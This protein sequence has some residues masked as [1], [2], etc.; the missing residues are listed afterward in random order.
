MESDDEEVPSLIQLE[1]AVNII[2]DD[3]NHIPGVGPTL[4]DDESQ[5]N[6]TSLLSPFGKKI[7]VIILS[8]FLGAGKSTLINFILKCPDHNLKIAVIENEFGRS[9]T[10]L[11]I[12]SIIAKDGVESL[13][14]LIELPNGCVCCTVKS[15]LVQ[16][17]EMLHKRRPDLDYY[18]IELSGMANPGPIA[19]IFWLDE[20]LDSR[21]QLNGIVTLVDAL[22]ISH[23]LIDT[24]EASQQIAYADRVIL[25]KVDLI[26]E[27][28]KSEVY[29]V[30][31]SIHPTAPIQCTS[32]A[33]IPDLKWVLSTQGFDK[34]IEINKMAWSFSQCIPI[35]PS[36]HK[37]TRDVGT[38]TLICKG[39]VDLKKINQWMAL[40]L[41]PN[42][43]ESAKS[44]NERL[45]SQ[46]S[47]HGLTT[48]GNMP[49][50]Q[51][52][53]LKGILSVKHSELE[54]E[55]IPFIDKY[56][57]DSR[58]YV[59][60]GV[61]DL[62]EVH[63]ASENLRWADDEERICNIVIIG[64]HLQEEVLNSGLQS[65]LV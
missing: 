31:R 12:E 58:R 21:L 25:N 62:W 57:V 52:F 27:K 42:Q 15:D 9:T 32:Y 26:S 30:I 65:C 24:E 48:A 40:L 4:N 47:N 20:A 60:Q 43:D 18:L 46:L 19:S 16:A 35:V 10:E 63:A 59:L 6:N 14:D 34:N 28:K 3:G 29:N 8:G 23:Q 17:L 36:A 51:I 38:V 33:A 7:P 13:T 5:V 45:E 1:D 50:M 41:W 22:N 2:D 61:Y 11:S 53:R 54:D 64:R 37:H 55:D 49:C 56:K 44:V 39:S